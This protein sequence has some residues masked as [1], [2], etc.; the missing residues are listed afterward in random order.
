M[1]NTYTHMQYTFDTHFF[2]EINTQEKAYVLGFLFADGYNYEKRG[3]VSL[4]LQEKDKEIL[5]KISKCLKNTK[6][7]QFIDMIKYHKGKS[8]QN[9]YRLSIS[10]HYTSAILAQLG[11]GQ[12]KSYTCQFPAISSEMTPHFLRGYFDGDGSFAKHSKEIEYTFKLCGTKEFLNSFS[13]HIN[14]PNR[15]LSK[16][17]KDKKNN[18]CLEIGGRLQV[19]SIGDYLYKDANVYLNRKYQR[20]LKLKNKI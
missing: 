19:V 12:K 8:H 6:P 15:N 11:C 10:S 4:S 7:L 18:W 9:Q 1:W 5:D 14:F 20:Y 2:D 16:R 3:V 17:K 13:E